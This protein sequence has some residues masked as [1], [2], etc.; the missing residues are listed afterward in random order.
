MPTFAIG[1][2]LIIK[3]APVIPYD[4]L[5]SPGIEHEIDQYPFGLRVLHGVVDCLLSDTQEIVLYHLGQRPESAVDFNLRLD[6][7]VM[8]Q[9]SRGLGQSRRQIIVFESR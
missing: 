3:T 4:E 8:S 7:S 1:S 5:H 2:H 9:S 6:S